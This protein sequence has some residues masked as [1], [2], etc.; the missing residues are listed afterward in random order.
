MS[1][2]IGIYPGT[3]DPTTIGHVD[4]ITRALPLVDLLIVGVAKYSEKSPLFSLDERV[5]MVKQEIQNLDTSAY[6]V[7]VEVEPFD[8]LL[9]DFARAK[10]A[11][12]LIRGLRAVSDFEY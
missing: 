10:K 2:R 9:V 3:F 4:I 7:T 11:V 12:M 1:K 6:D 8:N 5:A